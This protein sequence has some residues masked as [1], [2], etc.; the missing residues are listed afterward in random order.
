MKRPYPNLSYC[1]AP[2]LDELKEHDNLVKTVRA[3][4]KIRTRHFP[5]APQLAPTYSN[6]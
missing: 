3:Q 1:T 5:K 6:L 4:A 2:G